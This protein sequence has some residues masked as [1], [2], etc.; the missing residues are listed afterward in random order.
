MVGK[1]ISKT[2]YGKPHKKSYYLGCSTGGRQGFKSAQAFPEDFDGIVAGAP[3]FAFNNL[4][5]WSGHFYLL[6][7]PANSSTFVTRAQWLTV[8]ADVLK[9]CD[10]LD[11]LVDGVI[12]DPLMCQYDPSGLTCPEGTTHSTSC[13]TPTQVKTVKA[14]Y[15]PLLNRNGGLTYPRLQPGAEVV[16]ASVLLNGIPFSYTTDWFRYA[17]YNDPSWDPTTQD[18]D[19]YD[20]AAQ[21]NRFNIETFDGDLSGVKKRGAKVLH[22]HGGMD[23]IISSDNSPRYYEHVRATMGL[24]PSELD[25]FYRYFL[26]SG[27]GHCGGGDGAHAIGQGTG[28]VNSLHPTEN[29]LMALVDWVENKKAPETLIGT[30]W[31]ND[32]QSLGVDF[33]RAH[34]KYP[35]RNQYKGE[36]NPD[37][38]ESWAC[39]A[40]DR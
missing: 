38:V 27:T 28:E 26:V 6:T 34:C 19:D 5:S 21:L 8:H 25:E 39:V 14:V 23:A 18:L 2:F 11:G 20:Y 36:G 40:A 3:A 9:Q 13:L 33:Q 10:A 32:T 30:K 17:V 37:V 24:S 35:K 29:V 1:Q 22:W 31:V 12:E 4:T 7:G 15:E 16:A